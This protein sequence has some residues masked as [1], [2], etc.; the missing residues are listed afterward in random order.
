[1]YDIDAAACSEV[2]ID[3]ITGEMEI[4][5]TELIYDCGQ[6]LIFFKYNF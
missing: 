6:T 5:K 4:T 2:L 1:M 3:T